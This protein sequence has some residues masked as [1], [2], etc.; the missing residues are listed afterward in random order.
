MANFGSP[1]S[2]RMTPTG[3]SNHGRRSSGMQCVVML[4]RTNWS[5]AA[6][7]AMS[8]SIAPMHHQVH[9]GGFPNVTM[10]WASTEDEFR[11]KKAAT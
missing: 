8:T 4:A 9:D 10:S 7:T 11:Y 3:V 1:G 2:G 6:L 5:N